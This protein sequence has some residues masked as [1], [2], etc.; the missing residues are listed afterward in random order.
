MPPKTLWNWQR[1]DWP[2]FRFDSS[3]LGALEAEFL[4]QSGVFIG[5]VKHVTDDDRLHFTVDPISDEAL[6][7]SE[8]NRGKRNAHG[9]NSHGKRRRAAMWENPEFPVVKL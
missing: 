7:T 2:Q 6:H 1:D 4:R 5:A 8:E 9:Q 3:K